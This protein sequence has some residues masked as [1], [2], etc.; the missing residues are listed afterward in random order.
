MK[1]IDNIINKFLRPYT[2]QDWFLGAILTGS[3]AT[4]NNN[5]D[6]DIDIFIITK[7]SIHWRER[8]NRLIDG[9]MVEYFINPLR[10]VVKEFDEG[11]YT[12]NI[13]TTLMFAGSKLLYDTDGAVVALVERAKQDL[14]KSLA[15]VSEFRWNMNC[16]NVWHSFY[17]LTSKYEKGADIDFTYSIFLNNII[18]AHFSNSSIPMVSMHK[19]ERILT[20]KQYRERYNMIKMPRQEFCDRLIAC[21]NEKDRDRKY[22]RAKSLYEYYMARNSSFD[23]NNFSFR[24]EI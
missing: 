20:D 3:Y 22:V 16:Y 10:Q 15:P 23:I 19:M 18:S 4:G 12:N 8:G 5:P 7:D 11:F 1:S 6:S 2:E 9:Y 17:E 24:S 13:A 21:F 14:S